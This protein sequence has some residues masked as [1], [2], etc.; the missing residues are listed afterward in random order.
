MEIDLSIATVIA[1]V[2]NEQG[3]WNEVEELEVV[4][5]AKKKRLLGEDHP[6]TLSSMESLANM[7]QK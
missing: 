2:Y 4:M 1:H 6:D 7:Y 5:L 3:Q